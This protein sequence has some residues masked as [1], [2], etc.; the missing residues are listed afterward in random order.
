MQCIDHK[1]KTTKTHC[2][3]P[4]FSIIV[5]LE[6]DHDFDYYGNSSK[7]ESRDS[8]GRHYFFIWGFFVYIRD[9]MNIISDAM[10]K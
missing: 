10:R 9:K 5:L 6:Q 2:L 4:L 7:K 3:T 8:Q 1:A